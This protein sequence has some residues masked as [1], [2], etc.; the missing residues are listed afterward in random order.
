MQS[1]VWLVAAVWIALA[2]TASLIS[3]RVG[4]SV[5][6]V[7]ILVGIVAGNF[8]RVQTTPWIDFLATFGS[9]LLT[10]LAGAEI[11]PTDFKRH[12]KPALVIG[13]VSFIAPFVVAGAFAFWVRQ[14]GPQCLLHRRH[15]PVHHLGRRRLC[16]W[17]R[18]A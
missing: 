16:R 4:I 17:S 8:F 12:L 9:G 7:E 13:F 14:L 2:L 11:D 18:Q 3:I 6:L 10:F 5:A 1:N 15:R